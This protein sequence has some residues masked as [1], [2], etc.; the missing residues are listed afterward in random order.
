METAVDSEVPN[1]V[2]ARGPWA[3]TGDSA[4]GPPEP[5][6]LVYFKNIHSVLHTSLAEKDA[7][8]GLGLGNPTRSFLPLVTTGGS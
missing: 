8:F 6:K 7:W 4:P 3:A 1:L 5:L 2:K